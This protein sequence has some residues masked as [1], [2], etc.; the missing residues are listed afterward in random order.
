MIKTCPL[1]GLKFESYIARKRCLKQACQ[2]KM[3]A[4]AKR[5]RQARFRK[6]HRKELRE[7]G[8]ARAKARE[9]DLAGNAFIHPDLRIGLGP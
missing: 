5:K 4:T 6:A 1:C 7:Q 8:R 2:Q 9:I 3:A